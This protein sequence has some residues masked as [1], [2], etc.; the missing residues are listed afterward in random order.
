MVLSFLFRTSFQFRYIVPS[1]IVTFLNLSINFWSSPVKVTLFAIQVTSVKSYL[2]QRK[3]ILFYVWFSFQWT[4]EWKIQVKTDN[5][6]TMVVNSKCNI[7]TFSDSFHLEISVIC[8]RLQSVEADCC[9]GKYGFLLKCVHY[10][11]M[12]YALGRNHI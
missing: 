1:L 6:H 7:I 12:M 5:G 4:H 3:Q 8:Y 10:I 9:G 11:Q 2:T